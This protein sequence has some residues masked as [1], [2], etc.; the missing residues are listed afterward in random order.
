MQRKTKD[1]IIQGVTDSVLKQ[2]EQGTVPWLSPYIAQ[3]SINGH[4]YRG[5]NT[6]VL[7]MMASA[8]D[9]ASPYWLTSN[10]VRKRE[11]HIAKGEKGTPIIFNGFNKSDKLD[12][13][14]EEIWYPVFKTWTVFNLD[15]CCFDD[16]SFIDWIPHPDQPK[17]SEQ[18]I[19]DYL[20]REDIPLTTVAGM[21][22]YSPSRDK[23]NCPKPEALSDPSQYTS[24]MFHEMAHSTGHESRLNREGVT[25]RDAFGSHRYGVEELIAEMTSAY[26]CGYTG[27]SMDCHEQSAAYISHWYK[28]IKEDPAIL[29]TAC[30][31]AEKAFQFILEGEHNMNRKEKE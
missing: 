13:Q 27:D 18:I 24:T 25:Q 29:Q 16:H 21:A 26:L 7:N 28:R 11:G 31:E 19:R 23:I 30:T 12:D 14:G 15:Q 22:S 6:L 2:L 3:Q 17:Q 4:T 9:Y 1:D 8:H 10:A 20:T 5:I